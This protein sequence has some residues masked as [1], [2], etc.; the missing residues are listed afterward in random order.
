MTMKYRLR[1]LCAGLLFCSMQSA[2]A[3]ETVQTLSPNGKLA[4]TVSLQDG[5]PR[6]EVT[7]QGKPVVL[8]SALG[9]NGNGD[10]SRGMRIAGVTRSSR[11]TLWTPV[12]GERSEIPDRYNQSVI[13]FAHGKREPSL[14][15]EVR[16]YDEGAAFRYLFL[17]GGGY[18]H[19][20]GEATEFTLP[21]GTMAYFAPFA[22]AVHQKLPLH[23]WPGEADR[24][25]T[26]E[27]PG[28]LYGALA[29]AEVVDYVRTKFK[30]AD[31]KPN[32]LACSMYGAVDEI[33]PFAT[34]WRV[35][36]VAEQPG[37]LIENNYLLLN[38]NPPCAIENPWWI[39]PGKVMR[40]VTLSTKGA[41][42]LVDFAVK[43][44]LQYIEFD[45]GWYGHEYEKISDASRVN[46]DPRR[47]PNNDLDLEEVVRYANDRGIG[48]W[49]YVNQR[50][51][52]AQLDTILPLY[53]KW[54]IKGVKFGFVQVG[55]Q[56]WTKWMHDAVKKCAEN[57]LMVDIHD[58]YRP[59]GF[60]RTYPNLLTQ[61]GVRGNEEM[62]DATN[63]LILPFTRYVAGPADYTISYYFRNFDGYNPQMI[64]TLAPKA[65]AIH[66]TS[67]QQLAMAVVY[68]SP[69]QFLYWYDRPSD[70]RDE[71]ELEFFDR[72]PTVWDETKVLQGKIGEYITTARRKGDEW[73]VGVMNGLQPRTL[74]I[75]F[76]FLPAGKKYVAHI[77]RDGTM[78]T[79]T[80]TKVEVE[81][82]TVD[83]NTV[84]PAKLYGSGG[85]AI[86][87]EPAEPGKR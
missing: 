36:M 42:E 54:G 53:H 50:A 75:P 52:A 58:E 34:P 40:E 66:A 39:K 9:I 27:L 41:R 6:Y 5:A 46:V 19:I 73:F 86:R 44:N 2:A 28:G 70:S 76:N 3:Q 32:T 21:E 11:D 84:L 33:A 77:Y 81:T 59:T 16:A 13:R 15:L 85:L 30:L 64:D 8:E 43:R 35:V 68:Y 47:N 79:P 62:P 49:V 67:G 61:E 17:E 80:R 71:P 45:A 22:Q 78:K 25:L 24:P 1:L 82:R 60:S 56:M 57:Q 38:L 23:D 63:N 48:V 31:G 55:S 10:W 74:D 65:R 7:Y 12:Y 18:L 87:L 51:L 37:Q 14:E 26:L 72:V 4:I 69:L 20:T 29:E 83:A